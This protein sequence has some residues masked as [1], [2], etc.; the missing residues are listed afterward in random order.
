MKKV[1]LKSSVIVL[2][3]AAPIYSQITIQL[4]GGLGATSPTGNYA[5]TTMDFYN[6]TQYGLGTGF[7][8]HAK[9]RV[10]LLGF[11][12]LGMID[13]STLSSGEGEGEPGKGKV[14]NSHNIFSLK[15]GPEFNIS[16]PL[17]PLGFY[18]D[19]FV[20]VNTISGKVSFQGLTKIPS[21]EYDI[22]SATRFGAGA[23][24]GVLVDILPVVTLD[25]G[26]HYN[27]YNLFGK[28]YT[29]NLTSQERIDAYT[30]L[31]DDKDP[32]Y[33]AGDDDH[34]I[35]DSRSMNAWQFTITALI[36]I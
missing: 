13:Y 12:L 33:Q 1:I 21:G 14:Q 25:F 32:Q 17:F 30:S 36:G 26:I 8:L 3:I 7:N 23:G 6:G 19:G 15:A 28:Q 2:L 9:A 16:I 27:A 10:G 24:G 22:E 35:G 20:S 31:N 11:N 29:T 34:I 4:G 18:L 5:G